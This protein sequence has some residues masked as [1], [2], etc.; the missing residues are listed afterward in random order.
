MIYFEMDGTSY[1]VDAAELAGVATSC[2]FVN[3]PGLPEK[4]LGLVQ[5]SGK[6]FPAIDAFG[7]SSLDLRKCTMLFSAEGLKGPFNEIALAVRGGVK[8]FFAETVVPPPDDARPGVV[9]MLIDSDGNE[10]YQ[11][12]LAK[13][14]ESIPRPAG[15]P[16]TRGGKK[17]AA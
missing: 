14:A 6:V 13:V 3:Y 8:V 11:L 1:A 12:S 15:Q 17:I 2:P 7:D 5:W 16:R 4:V 10:A 9:A